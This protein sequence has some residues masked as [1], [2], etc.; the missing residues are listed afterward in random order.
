MEEQE[1]REEGEKYSR[2]SNGKGEHVRRSTLES[3]KQW[4]RERRREEWLAPRADRPKNRAVPERTEPTKGSLSSRGV[5]RKEGWTISPGVRSTSDFVKVA[6]LR[7]PVPRLLKALFRPIVRRWN[8]DARH[9]LPLARRPITPLSTGPES[10]TPEKCVRWGH[11]RAPHENGS[12]NYRPREPPIFLTIRSND[13]QDQDDQRRGC[14]ARLAL[15]KRRMNG[16]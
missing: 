12:A 11:C 3:R 5:G 13:D 4:L 1:G 7:G 6:S 15:G 9:L 14:L 16:R 2:Q 8:K 10:R